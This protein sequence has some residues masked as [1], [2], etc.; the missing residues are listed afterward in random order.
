M[1]QAVRAQITSAPSESASVLLDLNDDDPMYCLHDGFTLGRPGEVSREVTLTLRGR[2]YDGSVMQAISSLMRA[3]NRDEAY[4]LWQA[5]GASSPTWFRILEHVSE[6]DFGETFFDQRNPAAWTLP[7]TLTVEAYGYAERVTLPALTVTNAALGATIPHEIQGD[8]PT[9]ATVTVKPLGAQIWHGWESLLSVVAVDPSCPL[10]APGAAGAVVAAPVPPV[11]FWEAG[12][13][14]LAADAVPVSSASYS[15]GSAVSLSEQDTSWRSVLSGE[16]PVKPPPGRY[17]VWLRVSRTATAGKMRFRV[18]HS[19]W[20]LS[21]NND[22]PLYAATAGAADA[23]WLYVGD[24]S[25]PSGQ[26]YAGL[27][28]A[29]MTTPSI[30]LSVKGLAAGA[31]GTRIYL[32]RIALIPV[33]LSSS[34]EARTMRAKFGA[35]SGPFGPD[36]GGGLWNAWRLDG[37]QRRNGL[38]SFEGK[39]YASATPP[40]PRGG[41]PVLHPGM[42]NIVSL[43][44]KVHN[45]TGGGVGVE[46]VAAS[47]EIT[48]SYNPRV[49][50]LASS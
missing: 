4:L 29:D 14:T 42:R 6:L 47:C 49:A 9:L 28:D 31:V 32:D 37:E 3:V 13:F 18:G 45:A 35:F 26:P 24:Q 7:L 40:M 17:Q 10:G 48:V 19:G 27:S 20:D 33:G 39:W 41:F 34:V 38:V 50:H 15:G 43:L 25:F 46:S 11:I 1:T 5:P 16:V 44:H 12:A 21:L 2:G 23:A 22:A 30:Q 36:A 8:A